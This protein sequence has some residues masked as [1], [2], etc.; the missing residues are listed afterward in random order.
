MAQGPWGNAFGPLNL[1]LHLHDLPDGLRNNFSKFFGDEH[2]APFYIACGVHA[3][4]FEDMSIRLFVEILQGVAADWFYH[5]S[6]CTITNWAT[7]IV[8]FEERFKPPEDALA[9]LALME[10]KII[11]SIFDLEERT[12]MNL[13]KEG[14]QI[15]M[16]ICRA[17]WTEI[18]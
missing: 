5:F 10:P 11:V 3:I 9:L 8:K 15:F 16:F 4:E 14:I 6:S 7:L 18:V 2:I 13:E 17:R 1:A 12:N